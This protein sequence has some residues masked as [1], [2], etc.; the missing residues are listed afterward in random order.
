[1]AT[2]NAEMRFLSLTQDQLANYPIVNGQLIF[3]RDSKTIY[4]DALGTRQPF[5]GVDMDE[6][7][8]GV[9]SKIA[10]TKLTTQTV[11]VTDDGVLVFTTHQT[12]VMT[13]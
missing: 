9:I 7:A 11:E 2:T 12:D 4:L 6:V 10:T 13:K 1:M 8:A 5:N 3:V